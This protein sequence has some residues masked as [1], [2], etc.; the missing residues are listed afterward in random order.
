MTCACAVSVRVLERQSI[1]SSTAGTVPMPM[2]AVDLHAVVRRLI[3]R[4][5]LGSG[6]Q[7]LGSRTQD[8]VT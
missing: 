2:K 5:K 3:A 4:A 1:G 7:R 6:Y 8:P